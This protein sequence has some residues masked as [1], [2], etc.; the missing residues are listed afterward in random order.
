MSSESFDECW[1]STDTEEGAS[2]AA[3]TMALFIL[4]YPWCDQLQ[5]CHQLFGQMVMTNGKMPILD[6]LWC[7][8]LSFNL[9]WLGLNLHQIVLCEW[10]VGRTEFGFCHSQWQPIS[11]F[12]NRPLDQQRK[13]QRKVLMP[14]WTLLFNT[15]ASYLYS[16]WWAL[17]A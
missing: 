1:F 2:M 6:V 16:I 17:W 8:Y 4:R 14:R 13:A 3:G 12:A 5:C 9:P 15:I 11:W 7:N 10:F